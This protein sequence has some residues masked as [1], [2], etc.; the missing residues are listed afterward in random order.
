[1]NSKDRRLSLMM[2]RDAT[3]SIDLL[4]SLGNCNGRI[5]DIHGA[6]LGKDKRDDTL[7]RVKKGDLTG[8]G[9]LVMIFGK[10]DTHVPR[11]GRDLIR[12][13][14]DDADVPVSVSSLSTRSRRVCDA[15]D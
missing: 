4:I 11:A 8:K 13:T 12:S 10:Q 14:L 1:M 2:S 6:T 3:L 9:E 5:A 7:I 15:S